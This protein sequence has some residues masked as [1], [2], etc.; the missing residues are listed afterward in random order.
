MSA[1]NYMLKDIRGTIEAISHIVIIVIMNT[2][3]KH[4][5]APKTENDLDL[6]WGQGQTLVKLYDII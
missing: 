4:L 2:L 1:L 5:V 6:Y 3:Q